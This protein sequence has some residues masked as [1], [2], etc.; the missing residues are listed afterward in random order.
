MGTH[1]IFESDFDC[2]TEHAVSRPGRAVDGRRRLVVA[3]GVASAAAPAQA[4][5]A[6]SFDGSNSK[7]LRTTLWQSARLQLE[8]CLRDA[9]QACHARRVAR[10][11]AT[12][13]RW[14]T[15]NQ[16]AF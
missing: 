7:F 10:S 3:G 11:G 13:A 1:P 8:L 6:S 2:L 12:V 4:A 14:K 16:V 9:M 15:H 5:G